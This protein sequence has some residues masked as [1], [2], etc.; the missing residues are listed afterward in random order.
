MFVANKV[1]EIQ[2]ISNTEDW[3]YVHTTE[4]AAD[5]GTRGIERSKLKD[6]TLWRHGKQ[7]L[8]SPECLN[9]FSPMK[10]LIFQKKKIVRKPST[11][12]IEC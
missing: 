6:I 4:N 11:Q 12:K 8:Q 10:D 2:S 7:Y 3:S 5:L 1:T 9:I